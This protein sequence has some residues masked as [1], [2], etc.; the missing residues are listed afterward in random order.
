MK[1]QQQPLMLKAL[2]LNAA[3]LACCVAAAE[4][5]KTKKPEPPA[6]NRFS[7]WIDTGREKRIMPALDAWGQLPLTAEV[8]V[9]VHKSGNQTVLAAN[10]RGLNKH[11]AIYIGNAQVSASIPGRNDRLTAETP[12]AENAWHH[13]ALVLEEKA[14][15]IYVDG[16]QVARK[17]L[18]PAK[19]APDNVGT[20]RLAVGFFEYSSGEF[21]FDAR[22]F[23]VAEV[24]ISRTARAI[25]Q[26]PAPGLPADAETVAL[27][28]LGAPDGNRDL[29]KGLEAQTVDQKDPYQR[30]PGYQLG[31]PRGPV[32][33]LVEQFSDPAAWKALPYVGVL[34]PPADVAALRSLLKETWSALN[35]PSLGNAND[36]RD[37]LITDYDEQHWLLTHRLK[38]ACFGG[39]EQALE[40]QSLCQSGD[41]DPLGVVLRQTRALLG[42]LKTMGKLGADISVFERD[43]DA[44][45][46]AAAKAPLSEIKQ[47][48]GYF[49]AACL[50]RRNI[51]FSN[52]LLDFDSVLFAA[53]G[54]CTG[55]RAWGRSGTNDKDGQHFQ[56]QYFGFNSIPGGG[57]YA[58]RNFKTRPEVVDLLKDSTVQAGRT[59]G[60]KLQGGAFLS[61]DLSYDGKSILFS[62]TG[63]TKPNCYTWTPETT[64][65]IFRVNVDGTGLAQLTDGPCDD[66]DA[67][68]LP[69]G[70]I[71]FVSERR[72][73]Y[74]RCF[75]GLSVPQH[76]LHSMKADGSDIMPISFFSTGEWQ[77]SVDNDGMLVYT[78]WDYVDRENCLGSN[79]WRSFPDGRDPRAPH[80]NYPYPWHTFK[81]N[82]MKEGRTG[83]P[84]TEMNIR[85]IP[86]SSRYVMTATPH[87]GE[88]FGSLVMLDLS[89]PDDNR[90]SQLKR[91]TPYVP[92]PET[93]QETRGRYPYGT[94]WPL[95]EDFYL[96][97][98]WENLYLLDRYGNQE[99]I[100]ENS[101]V[102]NGKTNYSMRLMDPIPLKPR[103]MPP[104]IPSGVNC[105]V[106]AKPNAPTATVSVMNV[107]ESDQPFPEGTKI[108][109]LRVLQDIPKDNPDMNNPRN[110]G[111]Q[112]EN[113]PRI[114]LGI[115]PVESDGSV[116]FN[117]PV[118]RQLIFQP[119][120]DKFMAVQ[121]MRSV[122]YVQRGEQ[123]GCV[124][125]HENPGKSMPKNK[126]GP[127]LAMRRAPSN[128]E[129]EAGPVEPITYYR[130]VKPVFE[131]SC[132]GCHK[133]EGKGPQDMSYNAL[134]PY[135]FY[136]AGGM[137]GHVVDP[138]VGGSRSI[139]GRVGARASLMGQALLNATHAG[140][141]SP[142]DFHRV[143][144][145]LDANALRLGAYH[146]VDKQEKGE[147]V[148]WPKLDVDPA[149]P[150]GL[151]RPVPSPSPK[152][153]P[154]DAMSPS[155]VKGLDTQ[156]APRPDKGA[157]NDPKIESP[158]EPSTALAARLLMVSSHEPSE[159]N[160]V[161][162]DG[163]P[164]WTLKQDVVHPQD[165]AI[166][167]DGN[168][169]CSV[170]N[171]A[172]MV[173][174][175]DKKLLWRYTVPA[176]CENPVAQP[177][178]G[179]RFLV[180]NE[181]PCKLLEI[182]E[183][184]A[185]LKEVKG[186][187]KF[188]GKHGQ[189]R[190]CRK[191]PEG[192]Y[193]F[194]MMED[195]S[196]REYD[197]DG[198]LVF[199]ISGLGQCCAALRLPSGNTLVGNGSA[200][201]E[202][203]KDKKLVW[204][205]DAVA[206]GK[207]KP[208]LVVGLSRLKNGNTIFSYYHADPKTPDII[209][210]SPD[211]KIVSSLILPA[212]NKVVSVQA[213]DAAMRP[214]GEVLIR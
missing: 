201:E 32:S 19:T 122:V 68:H 99:L 176:N 78:R 71:A 29:V 74:I 198:K 35:L 18:Q 89:V 14:A 23:K 76:S 213:L 33:G 171:G 214:S 123:L 26:Q 108:K 199:E 37:A 156:V 105:G 212:I 90:M 151:E 111:Y 175:S 50:L 43:L 191:T 183:K 119:L 125:C 36:V 56:T 207:L 44:L 31:V 38:G 165:A 88:A 180:G 52:P 80:G 132:V 69:G 195:K 10:P 158:P 93:E 87:H 113:T 126:S 114:P 170:T 205:F 12:L 203:D 17:D 40:A 57:L 202:Y 64:W 139:P 49:F 208:A 16:A 130:M 58:V 169:F 15:T 46:T 101:L 86:G 190:I 77:P 70:R 174:L 53:R 173:R 5:G 51:A 186:Q 184:G 181:G 163:K 72:G 140:K 39:P 146:D 141:V 2:M 54:V 8:W 150:Q 6:D 20:G 98:Y 167:K 160:I 136:F 168:L 154:S 157:R 196:I 177:L 117:A 97:N 118:E 162:S 116:Y 1:T 192:T 204:R 79:F 91:I 159:V 45:Q 197:G 48:K 107:Y 62:W 148:V 30:T 96:C 9:F 153:A 59:A 47:R 102:F 66:F 103:T 22:G 112:Q 200:V 75:V 188:P 145:W 73:G 137:L 7:N 42:K 152:A 27:W 106:D 121:S 206:D 24:R 187:S 211:K 115:V 104:A 41:G 34:P 67:C 210:V 209:E 124:G 4:E 185:V 147:V 25:P 194:A 13:V 11:W 55:T 110:V 82:K 166:T 179:G 133:T 3:I 164:A 189:F 81:D 109:Y 128:L 127:P 100:C 134:K 65:K 84:M 182:D 60:R 193:L 120:D 143:V 131:R 95:S 21:A 61:P 135:V 155:K 178:E 138:I 83:R 149:N 129:P 142:E 85:A 94:P 92:F 144:L 161:A 63:N 172:I 28:R